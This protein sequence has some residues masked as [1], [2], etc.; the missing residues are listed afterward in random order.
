MA[1]LYLLTIGDYEIGFLESF[2]IVIDHIMGTVEDPTKD[3]IVWE[4]RLPMIVMAV[5][6][7][8]GLAVAGVTMQSVM[9]NP[10]ADPYTTG[11]S[12][13]ASFGATLALISGITVLTGQWGLVLNAFIFSLIPMGVIVLVSTI[14]HTSPTTMILS[15]IAVM[16]TFDAITTIVRLRA[17]PDA[18]K[19][20][21][22]WGVGSLGY[23][24]W[25]NLPIV[26]TTT[27]IALLAMMLL[28]RVLN[29]LASGD[30]SA[31][32]LG[33][34]AEKMRIICLMLVSF[35]TAAIV[36][37]TGT[38]GFVGL[39]CPHIARI[40]VGSD[41]RFL[42]PAS[43]AFGAFLVILADIIAR[44]IESSLQVGVI[45]SFIGGPM[46]L[47]ILIR[48]KREVW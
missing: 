24:D 2:R 41:N 6:V 11:I 17:D 37:F 12:S 19:E 47:Y 4:R 28:S 32:S 46:F 22:N 16:Y 36:S 7:G 35:A 40:F 15:G 1:G 9:K 44:S 31:K 8:V 23:A 14:R 26:I 29:I 45:L 5:V 25:S 43:A 10:L 21:Y 39:V 27:L 38:I 33:V 13:G 3:F 18:L 48:Q 30:E 42:I 20:V 34:D